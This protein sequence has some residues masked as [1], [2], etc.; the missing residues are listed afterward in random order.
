MSNRLE[1]IVLSSLIRRLQDLHIASTTCVCACVEKGPHRLMHV[2]SAISMYLQRVSLN[3]ELLP[4][5]NL[6][7]GI[8]VPFFVYSSPL[9]EVHI[10]S[11]FWAA[12]PLCKAF[13]SLAP[14]HRAFNVRQCCAEI[15]VRVVA[16]QPLWQLSLSHISCRNAAY[17][18]N[19]PFIH[20][21]TCQK[22]SVCS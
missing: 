19:S 3:A 5:Y 20:M 12:F 8:S 1:C 13:V 10:P 21:I 18:C 14:M 17:S 4:A 22:R 15:S 2:H 11:T 6:F 7:L 9:H 16:N